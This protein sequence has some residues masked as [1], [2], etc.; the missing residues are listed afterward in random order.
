[1][2]AATP[3]DTI[4]IYEGV[5]RENVVV[6]KSL[7]IIGDPVIDANGG[8]GMLITVS[9]VLVENITFTN[10]STGILIY[11]VS[12]A[13]S[14]I[15]LLNITTYQGNNGIVVMNATHC[16]ITESKILHS[17]YSG[18]TVQNAMYCNISGN[19]INGSGNDIDDLSTDF[20]ILLVNS[21]HNAVYENNVSYT[22][23]SIEITGNAS[24]IEP[25][26]L[27]SW[28]MIKR[29]N[30]SYSF[31]GIFVNS[32][33]NETM[34]ENNITFTYF[35]IMVGESENIT[36]TKN[37]F[38]LNIFSSIFL[39]NTTHSN[40]SFNE[41]N[42]VN[43][44]MT[45]DIFNLSDGDEISLIAGIWFINSS[46]NSIYENNISWY[47]MGV[48]M[49]NTLENSFLLSDVNFTNRARVFNNSIE[50]NN[51]DYTYIPLWI[52]GTNGTR[53]ERNN[54]SNNF[55]GSAIV[56][57]NNISIH[58]NIIFH[59]GFINDT[60]LRIP[61]LTL[62][63]VNNSTI[64]RN[65]IMK[66]NIDGLGLFS[67]SHDEITYNII[68]N[69]TNESGFATGINITGNSDYNMIMYNSIKYNDVGV[70]IN[71]SYPNNHTEFH[72][73]NIYGNRYLGMIYNLSGYM[74]GNP[75]INATYNCW[76]A[77]DGPGNVTGSV[78]DPVT[79]VP[80]NGSGDNIT[81]GIHFDPWLSQ[82]W[83]ANVKNLRTGDYFSGIQQAIDSPYTKDG[84][85]LLVMNGTFSE[86][87]VVYKELHIVGSGISNTTYLNVTSGWAMTIEANNV[88]I[89]GMIISGNNTAYGG[90]RIN[91]S[92][93][94]TL[95]N[96]IIQN[97]TD[98]GIKVGNG[99][100]VLNHSINATL[101]RGI[102]GC[103]ILLLNATNPSI[104]NNTFIN[105]GWDI[106]IENSS[107][108]AIENNYFG[109]QPTRASFCYHGNFSIKGIATPPPDAEG[110]ENMDAWIN[111]SSGDADSWIFI[112]MYYNESLIEGNEDFLTIFKWNGTWSREG[113]DG[114]HYIDTSENIVGVNVT[115]IGDPIFAVMQDYFPP[116]T[117]L[118]VGEPSYG[119]YVTSHTPIW[120]N[121]SDAG[122]GLNAT[123][124][125]IWYN[126]LWHP[127]NG[128]DYYGGSH[129]TLN[130]IAYWYVYRN[131][132]VT[133]N[134]IYLAGE[135]EHI[136][137][138]YS[139]DNAT[140]EEEHR[141]ATFYV[142]NTPPQAWVAI[143][144]GPSVNYYVTTHTYL[145]IHAED[146]GECPVES[147]H[148]KYN[149]WSEAKGWY[150]NWSNLP[151][152]DN[153]ITSPFNFTE[154]CRHSIWYNVSD[155]LGNYVVNNI[156]YKVDDTPP[157]S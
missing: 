120:L 107:R 85:T 114:E 64:K 90:I 16:N 146:R 80:A 72:Y 91:S 26:F 55:A 19:I 29:N 24:N 153:E 17:N 42:Q 83:H 31:I 106:I 141:N 147:I 118:T 100:L 135:C 122:Y 77:A 75:Y 53:I 144:S 54:L 18:I 30:I 34:A 58:G 39:I 32:T 124:Y 67:S 41:I 57:S 121:A 129:I 139:V 97:F 7:S 8:I 44:S 62:I 14:N 23:I 68:T 133:P 20:G 87:V 138:Y 134:P 89:S 110:F 36:I 52:F 47:I 102:A 12:F 38:L 76:G 155:D 109:T 150:Y 5:Y 125:R 66:N 1:I 132:T 4:K 142:D 128:S 111:V 95:Y 63:Y 49:A 10:A 115:N 51:L 104:H 94:V 105:N 35:G 73:N 70:L 157:T 25:P 145:R 6:N 117:D 152:F 33:D 119:S 123:Y 99:S 143:S 65:I 84:D 22:N 43:E 61:S 137:E 136:V 59:N 11:N 3:G 126:N 127:A 45:E 46:Y 88:S 130:G 81:H 74:P 98:Y 82:E 108:N 103:G 86:N 78:Y 93:N 40:I 92:Y 113:W 116:V 2:N 9:N 37:N 151:E 149:I 140:N 71:D 156:S 101:I 69:N 112:Y 60:D 13:I 148:I 56:L 96:L 27:F 154:E 50:N 15:T 79:N 21:S 28:N 131:A 48:S